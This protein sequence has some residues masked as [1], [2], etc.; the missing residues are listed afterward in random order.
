MKTRFINAIKF[1]SIQRKPVNT[2]SYPS[3]GQNNC[4]P[5]VFI[6]KTL[7]HIIDYENNN[8]DRQNPKIQ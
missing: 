1:I 8:R 5:I 6:N 2:I 3:M 7:Q 4:L